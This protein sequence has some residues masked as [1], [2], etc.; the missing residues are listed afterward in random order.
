[1]K[2]SP[3]TP[4]TPADLALFKGLFYYEIDCSNVFPG[5]LSLNPN[6]FKVK[7]GTADGGTVDLINFGS[8]SALIK[9]GNYNFVLY[10]NISMPEFAQFSEA[11]FIPIKD[12]TSSGPIST[13]FAPGR[14]LKVDLPPGGNMVNLD[15]NMAINPFQN[16]NNVFTSLVVP[17]L[18]VVLSAVQSGERKYEDRTD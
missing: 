14:Y 12:G 15:F 11:F 3:N 4:F 9:G 13:T 18:H 10:K 2:T 16:Y 5:V 7:V 6:P 1:M 17:P 8:I